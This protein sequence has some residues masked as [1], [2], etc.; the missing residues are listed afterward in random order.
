MTDDGSGAEY[1][2]VVVVVSDS[3]S[4]GAREDTTG[5]C[6]E[7]LLAK[8]G[9][10]VKGIVIIEDELARIKETLIRL[11]DIERVDLVVTAGGT[12]FGPRDVTPE[13]TLS[14]VERLANSLAELMRVKSYG[15]GPE[16]ALSRG[17]AGTRGETLI[18]NLPGSPSGAG[19][20]LEALMPILRHVLLL[21][22]GGQPH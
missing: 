9:I 7:E 20:N 14:I 8:A 21:I 6:I 10:G 15:R 16:A 2:A 4:T 3:A 19:E 11:S 18:V 13:A 17:I 12:G 5:P 1:E 22:S